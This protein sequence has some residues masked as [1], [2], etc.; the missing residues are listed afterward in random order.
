MKIFYITKNQNGNIIP[1]FKKVF[2]KRDTAE[3][4][5]EKYQDEHRYYYGRYDDLSLCEQE[6][7]Q[8]GRN[9]YVVETYHGHDYNFGGSS[10][11][12]PIYDILSYSEFQP[13]KAK[14]ADKNIL[15]EDDFYKNTFDCFE[16]KSI[17][18]IRQFRV[19]RN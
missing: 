8:V 6:I 16:D 9:V 3:E 17:S 15:S 18:H 12:D 4:E 7:D 13:Y 10:S 2:L 19:V 1:M 5:L 14:F 11:R